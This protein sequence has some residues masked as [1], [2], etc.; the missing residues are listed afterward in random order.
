MSEKWLGRTPTQREQ[1]AV[2]RAMRRAGWSKPGRARVA[3]WTQRLVLMGFA[4]MVALPL[5]GIGYH[6]PGVSGQ[7]GT[8]GLAPDAGTAFSTGP[9]FQGVIVADNGQ[10]LAFIG[11]N[12]WGGQFVGLTNGSQLYA[13][14]VQFYGYD[15]TDHP[16]NLSL[17]IIIGNSVVTKTYI[18]LIPATQES[19]SIALPS[20]L[21]WTKLTLIIGGVTQVY[22]YATPI[23][24]LPPSVENV[25]GLDLLVLVVISEMVIGVASCVVLAKWFMN[26]ALWAPPFSLLVYG[27]VILISIA[28]L[29][30]TDYQFINQTF[31]GWSPLVYAVFVIPMLFFFMLSYF[32]KAPAAIVLRANTPQAGRLSYH[33]WWIEVADTPQGDQCLIQPTFGGM[34]ARFWGHYVPFSAVEDKVTK[35][36]PF[37]A[38]LITQQLLSREEILRRVRRPSP[39]KS[40]PLDDFVAIPAQLARKP[41]KKHPLPTKLYWTPTGM[42]IDV[43]WPKL[44]WHRPVD[45]PAKLSPEG[46]VLVPAH[47]Q[48]K[49]TWPH[50]SEGKAVLTLASIHFR[51]VQSVVSG[52]RGV[53]DLVK[54][55]GD[56]SYDLDMM[57]A[58]FDTQVAQKVRERL[59]A[60]ESAIGRTSEDISTEEAAQEAE[61]TRNQLL[62]LNELYGS[63]VVSRPLTPAEE[64]RRRRRR[65]Q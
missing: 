18:S 48:Q 36:E 27:H 24:L 22:S 43:E 64:D 63:D 15:L 35:P 51:S 47:T 23:S 52:W 3:T 21:S 33:I 41:D 6:L 8:R 26:R 50:Y 31:A 40:N 25:G 7:D 54:V 45:V 30:L 44:S 61:R 65:V 19:T 46:Q 17:D 29:V 53:E 20:E 11:Y 38:E 34:W 5:I 59:L 16:V 57:K 14:A 58:T 13:N 42:P 12:T 1:A 49:L 32:N 9:V 56:T 37:V 55:L 60:R 10:V 62:D 28:A 39:A 2:E 4:M